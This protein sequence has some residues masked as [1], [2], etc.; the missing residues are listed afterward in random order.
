M[1]TLC[2]TLILTLWCLNVAQLVQRSP[3]CANTIS[4]TCLHHCHQSE[5]FI[6]GII[7]CLHQILNQLSKCC[8]RNCDSPDQ[9]TFFQFSIVQF[10][11]AS[12][13]GSFSFLFSAGRSGTRR[14]LLLLLRC[15]SAYSSCNK[16]FLVKLLLPSYQLEAVWSHSPLTSESI[17][18][19]HPMRCCSLYFFS[20]PFSVNPSRLAVSE[21]LRRAHLTPTTMP[22]LKWHK[23]PFSLILG[24]SLNFVTTKCLNPLNCWSVIGWLNKNIKHNQTLTLA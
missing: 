20:R 15:S 10:C 13:N 23:S 24:L 17:R 12:V 21:N 19:F 6:Q 7:S 22:H 3:R 11:W 14:G 1:G 4:S 2:S 8:S 18:R 5:P 16:F 9:A